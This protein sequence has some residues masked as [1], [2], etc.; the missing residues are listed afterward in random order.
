MRAGTVTDSGFRQRYR[1]LT[2]PF[3]GPPRAPAR[4]G[5]GREPWEREPGADTNI[6]PWMELAFG[7]LTHASETGEPFALISCFMNGQPAAI[8]AATNTQGGRTHILP[9]FMA[10]QPWMKFT[11]HPDEALPEDDT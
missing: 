3:E 1:E 4:V 2:E 8:I 11:P 6:E 10:V 7:G 9:L 5:R